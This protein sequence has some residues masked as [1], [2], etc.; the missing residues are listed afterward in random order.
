MTIGIINN[1]FG[2]S[3]SLEMLPHLLNLFQTDSFS[4]NDISDILSIN[5]GGGTI[6]IPDFLP[7]SP[8]GSN[9]INYTLP[10]AGLSSSTVLGISGLQRLSRLPLDQLSNVLSR[11]P[12]SGA[13]GLTNLLQ[14]PNFRSL[15]NAV[16]YIPNVYTEVIGQI[17]YENQE[18]FGPGLDTFTTLDDPFSEYYSERI[19]LS[20]ANESG[21]RGRVPIGGYYFN[22]GGRVLGAFEVSVG[23]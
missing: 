19:E 15:T 9:E 23:R 3:A 22:K 18:G 7:S 14:N 13:Q 11:I 2:A 12:G 17:N 6:S 16:K 8:L 4:G 10:I 20:I 21:V 5:E 1:N